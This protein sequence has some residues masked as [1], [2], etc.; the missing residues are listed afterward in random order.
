MSVGDSRWRRQKSTWKECR[1]NLDLAKKEIEIADDLLTSA[2][3]DPTQLP[4]AVDRM[5]LAYR[6]LEE[7]LVKTKRV[8]RRNPELL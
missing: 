1:E 7:I 8:R 5:A 6:F 3:D 2:A 4:Y